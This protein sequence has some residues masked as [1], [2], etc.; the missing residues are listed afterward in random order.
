MT[1]EDARDAVL[2]LNKT[3]QKRLVLE[4]LPEI[5]SQVCTDEACLSMIRNFVN[6]ETIRTYKEQHMDGI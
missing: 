1:Y 6:E 3:E 4:V 5:L 2:N